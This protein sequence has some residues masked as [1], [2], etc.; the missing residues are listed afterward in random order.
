MRTVIKGTKSIKEYKEVRDRMEYG[1]VKA[2]EAHQ[3]AC[4]TWTH[5]DIDRVWYD[6]DNILCVQYNDG[7]W[8]HYRH[9]ANGI[10]WW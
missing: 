4:E 9:A 7:N 2:Y 10:E 3:N 8:W 6:H 5:G 1:A